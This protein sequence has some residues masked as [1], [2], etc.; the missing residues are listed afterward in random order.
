MTRRSHLVSFATS[1]ISVWVLG[2][3]L[4]LAHAQAPSMVM[5]STTSTEQSGLFGAY[6]A[7]IQASHGH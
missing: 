6:V 4:S 1:L 2:A 7:G 3:T 5:A